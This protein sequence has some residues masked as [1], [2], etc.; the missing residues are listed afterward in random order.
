MIH[1]FN[2]RTRVYCD[3]VA[4]FDSEIV[5]DHTVHPGASIIEVIVRQHDQNRVLSF[6]ALD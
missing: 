6:L 5:A 2:V 1:V 4:V 3:N